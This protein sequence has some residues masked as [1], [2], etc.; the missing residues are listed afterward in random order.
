[1]SP[2]AFLLCHFILLLAF[3]L[4]LSPSSAPFLMKM[5]WH[6]GGSSPEHFS[7]PT[8]WFCQMPHKHMHIYTAGESS[9]YF[10]KP[11]PS[12]RLPFRLNRYLSSFFSAAVKINLWRNKFIAHFYLILYS[13]VFVAQFL[14]HFS[15]HRKT[16]LC[17]HFVCPF[18]IATNF[19]R[20]IFM[21]F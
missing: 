14:A 6:N 7:S 16:H 17:R 5:K 13:T 9:G 21:E 19:C 18:V 10:F 3:S 1:M 20:S 4:S 8:V 12:F 11:F 2:S 15:F